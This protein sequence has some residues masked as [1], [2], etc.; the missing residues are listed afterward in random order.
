MINYTTK[1]FDLK[2]LKLSEI[3]LHELTEYNRLRNIFGRINKDKMLMNPVIVGKVK[4]DFILLDGANRYSSLKDLKC[5]L[6]IAQIIN[7]ND[8]RIKL[9]KWNHLIYNIEIEKFISYCKRNNIRQ[10]EISYQEGLNYVRNKFGNILISEVKNGKNI[11]IHLDKNFDNMINQI[12][13]LTRIYFNKY[14]FDRSECE[15]NFNDL[16]KFSRK[17]G[18]LIEFPD[19]TKKHIIKA[20][21]SLNKIPSG[22]TRHLIVNRVLHIRYNIK[23]LIDE[24]EI[25]R[26]SIE[27]EKFLLGKIDNNKVR[28]YKESVI[29]FDE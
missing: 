20:A 8:E 9:K 4:N 3:K 14:N 15:I 23:N 25:G 5:K 26:K 29:V 13:R 6:I 17:K 1:Y 28:Q 19:F 2:I 24:N 16:R 10:K 11:L 7:Y 21:N 22:I 18:I 12:D 27:L